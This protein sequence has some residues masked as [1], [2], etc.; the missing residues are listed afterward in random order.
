MEKKDSY[1]FLTWM[2]IHDIYFTSDRK[3][4][5]IRV[6]TVF[7]EVLSYTTLLQTYGWFSLWSNFDGNQSDRNIETQLYYELTT[8]QIQYI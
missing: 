1:C 4:D 6:M 5:Y 8:L 7:I 3:I 2:M